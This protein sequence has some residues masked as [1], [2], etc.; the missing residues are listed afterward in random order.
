M[1]RKVRPVHRAKL[2]RKVNR[3]LLAPWVLSARK[4]RRVTLG[5][6][7]L[8]AQWVLLAPLAHKV[9]KVLPAP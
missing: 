2:A 6:K 5:L 9:N 1:A 4:V 3:E 7:A 8:P